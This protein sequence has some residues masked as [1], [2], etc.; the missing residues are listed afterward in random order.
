MQAAI[1]DDIKVTYE[2]DQS[3][4]T[5]SEWDK[6]GY[7]LSRQANLSPRLFLPTAAHNLCTGLIKRAAILFRYR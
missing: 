2:F 6:W 1:L 4:Y 5:A 7:P 3:G